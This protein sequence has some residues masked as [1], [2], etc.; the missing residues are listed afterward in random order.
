L[1][2][3]VPRLVEL[4]R[5]RNE[6]AAHQLAACS[7]ADA[8]ALPEETESAAV[9]LLLG[10]LYHLVDEQDRQAA[11]SE[12]IRVLRPGGV[13]ITAGI[14]RW[15]SA[16]DGL[17]REILR[18]PEFASI[19][20]RDLLDGNH[21]NPT[22]HLDYFTT[23][24]FHRPEELRREVSAAGFVIEGLYGVEGPGWILPDLVE[25]WND[26]QR[27][28]IILK[29]ARALES[30]SSVVGCSAHLIVVGR[31]PSKHRP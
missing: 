1:F 30:E 10:P 17:A 15:A 12:A 26:P 11:L 7:V 8:R 2:D 20:E 3:A 22:N 6:N 29:V 23:A 9:V 25:R 13:L 14:S 18:D 5:Q 27:R 4:A 28:E 16:L 21:L 24:Y 31:K 19:V